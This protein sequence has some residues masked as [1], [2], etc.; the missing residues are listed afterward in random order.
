[1]D[2]VREVAE[3]DLLADLECGELVEQVGEV[4]DDAR[5][6]G[7]RLVG[8]ADD[9]WDGLHQVAAAVE[10]ERDGRHRRRDGDDGHACRLGRAVGGA[11]P[12]PGLGGG[13]V[14][15]GDEVDARGDD[16]GQ[17]VGEDDRA[18]ELRQLTQGLL[19]ALDADREPAGAHVLHR[20]VVPEHDQ[21]SRAA[22]QDAVDAGPQRRPGREQL[23]VAAHRWLRHRPLLLGPRQ[24]R[25]SAPF[26]TP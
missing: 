18:V 11:M 9:L 7:K 1:M 8:A 17:V 21:R 16:G 5:Q 20:R 25:V 10:E 2:D 3:A 13:E 6:R 15:R 23:Q 14:A 26:A 24:S 12:G 4:G 22:L 19:G